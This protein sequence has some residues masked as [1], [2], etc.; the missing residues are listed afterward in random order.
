LL[1]KTTK[2]SVSLWE[3]KGRVNFKQPRVRTE[4]GLR[5]SE[6]EKSR[7]GE[8]RRV[9]SK[10]LRDPHLQSVWEKMRAKPARGL[11]EN[12]AIRRK[13]RG[14]SCGRVLGTVNGTERG[15][16]LGGSMD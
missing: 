15:G 2:G 13:P 6:R 1:K 10:R 16:S 11:T 8:K 12:K 7:S 3:G 5:G 9:H 14:C 4:S